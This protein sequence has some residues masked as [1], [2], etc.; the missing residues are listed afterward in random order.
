MEETK[1]TYKTKI[2]NIIIKLDRG[3]L[4]LMPN[5]EIVLLC[6]DVVEINRQDDV[7]HKEI[8]IEDGGE[9]FYVGR[10]LTN[11]ITGKTNS[12]LYEK[13]C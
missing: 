2:Y 10:R 13:I 4:R 5:G 1:L 12:P 3:N 9:K 8:E 11:F 6:G 7:K